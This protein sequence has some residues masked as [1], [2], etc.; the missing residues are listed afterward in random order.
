MPSEGGKERQA[1]VGPT[2]VEQDP[3]IGDFSL[4]RK[5]AVQD[6]ASLPEALLKPW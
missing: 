4:H 3:K 1:H 2:D 5:V 6:T